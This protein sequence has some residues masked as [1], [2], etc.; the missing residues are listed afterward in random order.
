MYQFNEMIR[1]LINDL[2]EIK[3]SDN[4]PQKSKLLLD[5]YKAHEYFSSTNFIK[6]YI[7][8]KNNNTYQYSFSDGF[9]QPAITLWSNDLIRLEIYFWINSNTSTHDHS[10]EGAFTVLEGLSLQKLF[11]ITPKTENSVCFEYSEEEV[12]HSFLNKGQVQK[13][14]SG[15]D[16]IHKIIHLSIPTVTLIIRTNKPSK[17]QYQFVNGIAFQFLNKANIEKYNKKIALINC[18]S[19]FDNV[20]ELLNELDLPT[21][22]LLNVLINQNIW[23]FTPTPKL[24]KQILNLIKSKDAYLFS[25][26]N[27]FNFNSN[28]HINPTP[29]RELTKYSEKEKLPLDFI[30]MNS[31]NNIIEKLSKHLDPSKLSLYEKVIFKPIIK[32]LEKKL[33]P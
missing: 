32:Y 21:N 31:N 30:E 4:I 3:E 17:R 10:F 9:G 20:G 24:V 7:N 6:N 26:I 25:K 23:G 15:H 29:L 11:K 33:D 18:S 27:H 14:K 12:S 22:V 19:H 5:K 28:G 8:D 16:F 13:I 2:S 1:N